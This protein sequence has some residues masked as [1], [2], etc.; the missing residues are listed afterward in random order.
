[1]SEE[2][3]ACSCGFKCVKSQLYKTD[4]LCPKCNKNYAKL[5]NLV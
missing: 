4:G 2:I 3:V 1:M 5:C